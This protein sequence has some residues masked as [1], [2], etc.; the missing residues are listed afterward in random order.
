MRLCLAVGLLCSF[1]MA[2]S[3]CAM[4]S[5][6]FVP[7]TSIKVPPTEQATAIHGSIEEARRLWEQA[8]LPH[9]TIRDRFELELQAGSALRSQLGSED[10]SL[11]GEVYGGGNAY[12]NLETLKAAFCKKAAA[13]GGDVVLIFGTGVENRP[14]VYSTPGY[15]TTS[16]QYSGYDYGTYQ[17]GTATAYTTYTPGQVYSGVMRFPY[18]NGLVFKYVPGAQRR[19][20]Q[21]AALSDTQLEGVLNELKS[22]Y[23]NESITWDEYVSKSDLLLEQAQARSSD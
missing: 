19:R 16:M 1:L 12:S 6:K 18:A 5:V 23:N 11:I 17:S 15:S 8:Q 22:L 7:A 2:I 9:N 10:Y 20:S 13:V 3:G 4:H 14:F 21:M